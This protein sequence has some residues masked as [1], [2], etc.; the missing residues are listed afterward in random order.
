MAVAGLAE[1][2][3]QDLVAGLEVHDAR[4]DAATLERS[5]HRG[6]REVRVTGADVEHDGDAGEALAVRGH[7]IGQVRQ[8]L[9]RQ[10]VD[11]DVAEILEQ[12]GRGGLAAPGQ[13][14]HHDD[15]RLRSRL[16]RGPGSGRSVNARSAG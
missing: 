7:E 5:A 11:D 13:A 16:A 4:P 2:A 8:Q 1:P 12:L 10:V 14:A 3:D 6:E 9:T 15:G